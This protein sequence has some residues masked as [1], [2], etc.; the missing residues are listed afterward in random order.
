MAL[1]VAFTCDPSMLG[2]GGYT[3]TFF[4]AMVSAQKGWLRSFSQGRESPVARAF[5]P[6][7]GE[8]ASS[9]S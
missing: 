6:H 2:T 5:E 7:W 8:K 9:Y 1:P 3:D 4:S